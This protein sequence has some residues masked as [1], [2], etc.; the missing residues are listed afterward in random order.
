MA[1]WGIKACF[2]AHPYTLAL[3]AFLWPVTGMLG[4]TAG[5]HRLW[6]HRSYK[7]SLPLRVLLMLA[8]CMANQ[9]PIWHW[10]RDHRLH[11]RR[12]VEDS[13][14]DPHNASRGFWFSHIG[15][16]LVQK[17]PAVIE[18]GR[19]INIKDVLDDPV[20]KFQTKTFPF[21]PLLLCFALPAYLATLWGD[22]WLNGLLI[23]GFLRYCFVL[24]CTW[25]V[26]SVAHIWG[27]RTYDE[28]AR[29]A[30]NLFV[31][32]L[33]VGEGAHSYHHAY[34][35]SYTASEFGF[36]RDYNPTKVFIDAMAALGLAYDRKKPSKIRYSAERIAERRRR[37]EAMRLNEAAANALIDDE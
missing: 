24:H 20:V 7:A 26:N 15:W 17:H 5:A 16:L 14:A 21:S 1:V 23:A 9:G 36:P 12:G 3:A 8:N 34:P 29:P 2:G 37:Q 11:H 6:A 27:Y 33:A 13:V 4:I 10:V 25:C 31:S 22:S 18:E 28:E 30:D 32:V 19:K 35:S